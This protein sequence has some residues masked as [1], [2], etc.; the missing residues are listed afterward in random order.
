[1]AFFLKKLITQLILPPFNLLVLAMLGLVLVKRWPRIG[2]VLTWSSLLIIFLLA[3]PAVAGFLIRSLNV[4]VS[5]PAANNSAQA[6]VILGGGLRLNTP[7]YG[8]TLGVYTLDRVRYGATLAR[9][10]QLPILLSGG[11]V[12]V[13]P[14]EA[15]VMAKA[16]SDEF[17]VTARWIESESRDSEDNLTMSAAILKAEHIDTVLLVTHDFHMRR[18]LKHCRF[19]GLNCIP[20]PVSFSGRGSGGLW[21]GQLPSAGALQTSALAL[22]EI[23]GNLAL[24]FHSN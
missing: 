2:R 6:I 19:A 24:M 12:F 13:P 22:H 16:L 1:M 17:G 15:P 11:V 8:D 18:A 14:A 9:K 21:I 4:P 20:A 3:T 10:T 7:E 5:D 23:F